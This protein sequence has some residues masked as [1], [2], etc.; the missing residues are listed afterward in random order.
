MQQSTPNPIIFPRISTPAQEGV[1]RVSKWLKFQVLLDNTEMEE[2]FNHLDNF[3]LFTVSGWVRKEK[4]SLSKNEF[5]SLY[6]DYICYLKNGEIPPVDQFKIPFSSVL[7]RTPDLLYAQDVGQERFLIKAL[8][9]VIQLQAH[10]FFLSD[11]DYKYHPMVLSD[12]SISWGLQISYPQIF[13]DPLSSDFS[14]VTVSSDFPNS[15]LF[16][17]LTKWLRRHTLPTP[18]VYR[19]VKTHVPIRIGKRC[20]PWIRAHPQ[21]VKRKLEV[22]IHGH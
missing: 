8:K 5:I 21:L 20:L 14:K 17:L 3:L 1:L 6:S 4:A 22:F 11:V 16:I 9:P 2:L 19:D 7:T 13:Q 10:H 15:E 18:F 12:E